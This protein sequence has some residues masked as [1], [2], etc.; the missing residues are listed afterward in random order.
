MGLVTES[1]LLTPKF[2]KFFRDPLLILIYVVGVVWF[3][4]LP[5]ES[6]NS[7]TY[8]SESALLPG[9]YTIKSQIN[10]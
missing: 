6:L 5:H 1:N 2:I 8:F 9:K 3:I 4:L 10:I 7:P